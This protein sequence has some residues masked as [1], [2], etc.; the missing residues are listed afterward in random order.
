[1]IIIISILF[2]EG[3]ILFGCESKMHNQAADRFDIELRH[4]SIGDF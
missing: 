2:G 3:A 4:Q 1:M